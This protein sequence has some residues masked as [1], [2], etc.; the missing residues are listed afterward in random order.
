MTQFILS[1]FIK[2]SIQVA[3]LPK[4]DAKDQGMIL[5]SHS[6]MKIYETAIP[7]DNSQAVQNDSTN[8]C[9]AVSVNH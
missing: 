2:I 3:M 7:K 5:N 8:K 9:E 6:P 4:S 1:I